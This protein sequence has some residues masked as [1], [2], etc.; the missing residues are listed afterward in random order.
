MWISIFIYERPVLDNSFRN[1]Q[2][3]KEQLQDEKME[4]NGFIR[5]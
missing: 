5:N 4:L 1:L 2:I 3:D